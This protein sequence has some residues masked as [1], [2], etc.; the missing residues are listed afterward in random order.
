MTVYPTMFKVYTD[1]CSHKLLATLAKYYIKTLFE[2]MTRHTFWL[3]IR[4][5]SSH[6]NMIF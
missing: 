5:Q 6:D 3:K 1:Q 2:N 4:V